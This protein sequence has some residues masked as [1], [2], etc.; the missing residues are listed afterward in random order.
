[1]VEREDKKD[2][3]KTVDNFPSSMMSKRRWAM[4]KLKGKLQRFFRMYSINFLK[5]ISG[6]IVK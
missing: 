3:N 2:V 4:G 1:M 5:A 6:L